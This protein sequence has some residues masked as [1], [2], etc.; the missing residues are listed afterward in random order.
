MKIALISDSHFG[1]RND[2]LNFNEY[3]FKF[4]ENI[5]FPTLVERGITTC[6]HLGDVVDRRKY[7]SYRIASDFRKRFIA[8]FQRLGIDLHI[9]IGNHDT[10]YKNTSE[11]NSMDELVGR[12]RMWIYTEPQ[13]IKFN[14]TPISFMPWINTNNYGNAVEFLNTANTD[15]LIGHLEINGFQMYSGNFSQVGYDRELFRRFDTVLSGHFHHKSD[16]GQIYY[17]GSPY[18]MTW[19]DYG[20]PKGFHIFDTDTRELERIV[21]PY[22]FFK[23]I[24][25]DDTKE[26]YS[27]HD[28]TQYREQYVK[29]IVINKKDLYGFD[30]FVDRLLDTDAH[31]VKIIEDFS[32]LDAINVSDDI[33]ENTEDTMTLLERYVDELDVVLDKTRLKNTMKALYS[34]AQDLEL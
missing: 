17:L 13:V 8:E 34:E 27:S 4:Y 18:E 25:Y 1:A 16:D 29:L 19:A 15:I 3:F 32:D 9:I 26:D 6:I 14:D 33:V 30:K 24:Y 7:I 23:K 10:Y 28:V 5:F 2:N 20:S 31:D 11:I 21:N 12:D 22:T